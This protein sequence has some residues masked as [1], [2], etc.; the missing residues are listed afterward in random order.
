MPAERRLIVTADDFGLTE[1][2]NEA[3]ERAHRDGILTAA[4]LMVGAP[5]AAD[6]VRRAQR[7]PGLGVG[8]HLTLVN[9]RAVLPPSAL[10]AIA[11]AGELPASL[12][13]AGMRYFFDPRARRELAAE[14]RAQFEAFRATG[15]DLDHV[16]AHCHFHLHPTV[17]GLVLRIGP[18]YGL[19]AMRLPLEGRGDPALRPWLA[20]LRRRLRRA[21]VLCND[22]LLGLATTGRMTEAVV[23]DLI[24]RLPAGVS[25]LYF[26]PATRRDAELVRRMPDYQH[27]QE[28]AALTSPAVAARLRELGVVRT[29]F[30][31][32]DI[33]HMRGGSQNSSSML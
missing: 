6:A 11:P 3:V 30:R 33:P 21:G 14:I 17:L 2:V 19:R 31:E 22:H 8:L 5:A 32:L 1:S 10:P 7:M 20:W 13:G 18:A 28:L 9:G 12:G 29:T 4:S 25:E 23:L 24:E 26:H 27:D 16:N 15:L